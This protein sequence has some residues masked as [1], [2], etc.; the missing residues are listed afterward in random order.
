[1]YYFWK[2]KENI[3]NMFLLHRVYQIV[4]IKVQ[5]FYIEDTLYRI[6]AC[7]PLAVPTNGTPKLGPVYSD[8]PIAYEPCHKPVYC[9]PSGH[10]YV[11]KP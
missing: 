4:N 6:N 10:V 3:N 11:P 1:M 5:N 7:C 9:A 8:Y 2:T